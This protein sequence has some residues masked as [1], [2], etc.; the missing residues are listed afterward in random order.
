MTGVFF[1]CTLLLQEDLKRSLESF[2]KKINLNYEP[3]GIDECC[4]IPLILS[5]FTKEAREHG[6]KIANKFKEKNIDKIIT[7]CPHCFTAFKHEYSEKLGIN[8]NI[9]VFHLTQFVW[10]LMKDGR[11]K[12]KRE[13]NLK[14]VYHDPCYTGRQGDKIFEEPRNILNSIKGINLVEFDLNRDNSTC[15]GGGGLLRAVYPKLSVEVAKEKIE[16]QS[17]GLGVDA[18]VSCCPFCDVNLKEGADELKTKI[19][20]YDLVNILEEAL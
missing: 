1:G 6:I 2:L 17:T 14:V 9:P 8:M 19:K 10:D 7:H 3:L 5:G 11:L 4:G 20:V 13:V 16:L 18:I 15:C 12:T